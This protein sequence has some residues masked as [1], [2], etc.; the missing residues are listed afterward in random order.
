MVGRG[1]SCDGDVE[2]SFGASTAS[3]VPFDD[4]SLSQPPLKLGEV[5]N[6]SWEPYSTLVPP[7]M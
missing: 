7:S 1:G 6:A 3:L 5:I 2:A 4:M